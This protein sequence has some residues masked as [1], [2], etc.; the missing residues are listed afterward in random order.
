MNWTNP[1]RAAISANQRSRFSSFGLVMPSTPNQRRANAPRAISAIVNCVALDE[2]PRRKPRVD[3]APLHGFGVGVLLN[4]NH[5]ALFGRRAHQRPEH[6][7]VDRLQGRQR[8]VQP[9]VDGSACL[10]I[11]RIDRR[12]PGHRRGRD[13]ASPNWIP[14]ARNRRRPASAPGRWD[15]WRGTPPRCSCR[16]ACRHRCGHRRDRVRAG[17]TAL[18]AR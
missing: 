4:L 11:L 17:T 5:V 7:P 10:R 13:S 15:L 12:M 3:D 16:T 9:A 14:T 18:F 8:P 6:R 1:G 2:T